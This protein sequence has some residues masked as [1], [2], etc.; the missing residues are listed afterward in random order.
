MS[1]FSKAGYFTFSEKIWLGTAIIS[2]FVLGIFSLSLGRYPVSVSEILTC[3]F[4]HHPVNE[5]IPTVIYNVRMPRIGGAML[6]GGALA[7]AGASYQGMFRNPMV[8][9][10]I[11]GVTSGSGFGAALGILLSLPMVGIQFMAFVFGLL[12]VFMSF[13][14]SRIMGNSHDKTLM[15]VLSGMVIAT[16]F[17]SFL[18]LMKYIADPDSKLPSITY[19]LMGSLSN[20]NTSDLQIVIPAVLLGTIPLLLTGWKLNVLSFGEEEAQ[21]LGLHTDRLRLLVVVCASLVTASVISIT[22]IIGWVGLIIP[23]FARLLIGPDHKVLLPMSFLMGAIFMLLVDNI[24]RTFTT[25][26]IPLGILTAIIGAPFFLFFLYKTPKK[27]W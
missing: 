19:W 20:L 27:T 7:I 12:A 4:T 22:G 3:L 9:P 18:S 25:L 10:D 16:L 14:I 13:S 15:L 11:L 5:D 6:V 2:L 24:A 17:G 26:E 8:S 21:A 1:T 23:H